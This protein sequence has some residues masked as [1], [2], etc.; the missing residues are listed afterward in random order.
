MAGLLQLG[1][2]GGLATGNGHPAG[3]GAAAPR[4][5]V[6]ERVR[7]PLGL[8]AAVLLGVISLVAGGWFWWRVAAAA[9]EV[10]PLATVSQTATVSGAGAVHPESSFPEEGGGDGGSA[11]VG[12]APGPG[13]SA[14]TV[15]VHVAGAVKKAGVVKVPKGSRVHD[16]IAAAGGGTAAA[17]LNRL[18]A[19][20]CW[21]TARETTSPAT[22]SRGSLRRCSRGRLLVEVR[23]LLP[24]PGP[25][26]RPRVQAAPNPG[27]PA[28]SI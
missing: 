20:L 6:A 23:R 24:G 22:V 3:D 4:A 12:E 19:P 11:A 18:N 7:W 5:T 27:G 9:P 17:D 21:T 15:V 13:V 8:R 14:G 25:K 26:T 16:A 2:G 10:M 1:N 28:K